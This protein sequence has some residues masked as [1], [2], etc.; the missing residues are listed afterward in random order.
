MTATDCVALLPFIV[1]ATTIVVILLLVA[2]TRHHLLTAG[3]TVLGFILAAVSLPFV[4]SFAPRPITPLL[5]LDTY[6]IFYTGLIFAAGVVVTL[7]AYSY[8]ERCE[9]VREEFYLLLLLSTLGAV[10]LVSSSHFATFFLG[11][12]LLSVAL[13]VLIAYLHTAARPLEAGLK[14]LVL[15]GASSAFLLFGMALVYAELGTMEFARMASTFAG[16]DVPQTGLLLM[17]AAMM[18]TGV[19][20]KLALVPFHMWTPDVYE[21]ASAPVA[22]FVATVSKGAMV[23]LLLRSFVQTDGYNYGALLLVFGLIAVASMFT[24]NLLALLQN[25]VK[26]ILAYSSIAHLG[27]LL[28]AFLAGG[29]LAVEAVSFYVVAY[30]VTMLGA[31]GVVTVLSDQ[32]READ[33]LEDYRGL[34]WRH[35]WLA[36]IF[37]AM[38]LSLAGIPLTVG[39][40]GKFY[41]LAAG[42]ESALWL[43]VVLLV[44]NSAIGLFYYLRVVVALYTAPVENEVRQVP[45]VRR[46]L[47]VAGG[48][49]LAILTFL[50][51]WLGV[52]PSPLLHL[53]QATVLPLV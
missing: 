27:Y 13:Y 4:S 3:L 22:A 30:F 24:G 51:V 7:L 2:V 14:Y 15:A 9:E 10:V 20:F 32:N 42:I 44:I 38:L 49:A 29:A 40:V 52:Y 53:I 5:I 19:G 41:V 35:P 16:G 1:L 47:S 18:V 26:R 37:T 34:F 50:L 43:L 11:L 28:V 12:E 39:F 25:N 45:F 23:A 8:L 17:G 6:G 46:S 33:T 21:G 36:A 31:F 48:V